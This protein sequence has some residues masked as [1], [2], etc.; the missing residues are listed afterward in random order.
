MEKN[1]KAKAKF[2]TL[3]PSL[4]NEIMRYIVQLKSEESK[5]ENVVRVIQYLLGK[6]K[7]LGR[8][9]V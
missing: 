3:S 1:K 7:F 5:K 8:E 4:Q 9:I 6:S 2:E